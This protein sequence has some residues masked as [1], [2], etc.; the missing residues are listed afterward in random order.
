MVPPPQ[1]ML[2]PESPTNVLPLAV[3]LNLQVPRC[4]L[5]ATRTNQQGI[6]RPFIVFNPTMDV[7]VDSVCSLNY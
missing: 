6:Y 7:N 3:M 4:G 2:H 5:R 1:A